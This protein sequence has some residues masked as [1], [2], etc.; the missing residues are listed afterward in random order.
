MLL[1]YDRIS[2]EQVDRGFIE[3]VTHDGNSTTHYIPHHPVRKD[4][5][6]T[7]IRIMYDCSCRGAV[8][9]PSLNDCLLTGPPF[10]I[11][12]VS[13]ILR[14][15][16]KKYGVSTDIEKV[17]LHITLHP[18]DRDFIRFLW[19]SNASD[20][21]SKFK[22]YRFCTVLFGSV[23]SPFMLFATLNHHLLQ[24]D[25][26][27]SNNIRHNL[28]VDNIVT[29]FDSEA[30]MLQFYSQARSILSAAKFNL[31]A[32]AS[33]CRQLRN[34]V[35][36]DG[37]ADQNTLT[38]ILGLYWNTSLDRLSLALKGLN[39]LTTPLTTKRELL[40]DSSKLFDPL[41]ILSPISVRAKLLM[42]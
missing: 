5:S 19:L 20:P 11:D 8:D 35:D 30:E 27:V 42:Q 12:L 13:I 21:N 3:R 2:K 31:R 26:P 36:K 29:G 18:K 28:Y 16:L 6:T 22:T 32:W 15:H 39:H 40:Q 7:P 1:T 24:Y 9:Q 25:T 23:S 4:S 37:T 14:F 41:G 34:T 17:L 38:N 33:N 10:L